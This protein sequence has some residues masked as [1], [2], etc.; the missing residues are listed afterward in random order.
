MQD[1]PEYLLQFKQKIIQGSA[2]GQTSPFML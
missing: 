1:F 2:G